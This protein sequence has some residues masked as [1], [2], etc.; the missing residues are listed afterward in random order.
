M[1]ARISHVLLVIV[2]SL[3]LMI[4]LLVWSLWLT[5]HGQ[6]SRLT[7]VLNVLG[8]GGI[9]FLVGALV[10]WQ[11]RDIPRGIATTVWIGLM[12]AFWANVWGLSIGQS[13]EDDLG[14]VFVEIGVV[15]TIPYLL[16]GGLAGLCG[17]G[18]ARLL[19]SSTGQNKA[20]VPE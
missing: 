17:F 10:S 9:P 4:G 19:G 6:A 18:V 2:G 11:W 20:D 13:T 15:F 16:L 3:F 1:P 12:G 5:Y 8:Y 14:T 7:D